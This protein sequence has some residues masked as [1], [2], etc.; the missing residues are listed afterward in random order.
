MD[1]PLSSSLGRSGAIAQASVSVPVAAADASAAE[2]RRYLATAGRFESAADIAVVET[3]RLIGLVPIEDLLCASDDTPMSMDDDPP[4][5]APD[6]DQE[7]AA[8]KAVE[9]G[10]G[11][12][13]V[14]DS[15]GRL[16]GLIP[17]WRMLAVLLRE[18]DEDLARLG[19]Y[20]H[21][22]DVARSAMTEAVV[23]RFWHRLPWLLLGLAAAMVAAGI[24]GGFER[25]LEEE[26]AL[27]FFLRGIVYIADA[28]GTQ[29][30]S[31][32]IRG[33]SVGVSVRSI[34]AR[35][36]ATGVLI[37]LALALVAYPTTLLWAS[38][39]IAATFATSIIAACTVSTAVA[40]TL[41]W[42]L[43]ASGQDP[44][45]GSGPLATVCQD[46]LSI[47]I[48]FGLAVILT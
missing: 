47:L 44:A 26:V 35:E 12:L 42:L 16:V 38:D 28:V 27:A 41:P 23:H 17:P 2:V 3:G 5:I 39:G 43:R 37:G 32:V 19:G 22:T 34:V 14:V 24:V 11:A 31:V 29:T 36:L 13:A 20:L 30:E 9:H 6:T 40:M 21:Q 46:L 48:Y 8:C 25:R 18:H 7:A 45:F 15:A 4:V 33:L 1:D 10:R